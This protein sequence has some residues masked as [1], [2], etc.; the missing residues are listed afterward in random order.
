MR[1]RAPVSPRAGVRGHR[2]RSQDGPPR[3]YTRLS[4]CAPTVAPPTRVPT[5]DVTGA[6]PGAACERDPH[7]ATTLELPVEGE[8]PSLGGPTGW[9]NSEP[10]TAESLRG[11][12][13][14]VESG[15]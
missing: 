13:V 11:W 14:L 8:L 10:L 9:L 4:P 1:P 3:M 2:P 5:R 15:P 12:P 7:M 6:T